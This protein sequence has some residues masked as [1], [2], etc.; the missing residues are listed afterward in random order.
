MCDASYVTRKYRQYRRYHVIF[1]RKYKTFPKKIY[2]GPDS[3][4]VAPHFL[5]VDLCR[6]QTKSTC[7]FLCN[8]VMSFQSEAKHIIYIIAFPPTTLQY[9]YHVKS[10]VKI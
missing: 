9:S 10:I 7:R 5:L 3:I 4:V 8:Q 6:I 1:V 2:R